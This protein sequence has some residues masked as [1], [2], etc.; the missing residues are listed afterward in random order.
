LQVLAERNQRKA[1]KL[2]S[3]IDS[4]AFYT[5]PVEPEFRSWM[6]VPFILQDSSL[7]AAFLAEASQAGLTNLKGHRS[8]GGM[9][10]SI[11]NAMPEEGIDAL[12]QFM[13]EFERSHG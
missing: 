13:N 12:I 9:R 8:V 4:S 7:D 11:Y 10:A 6:N 1:Q 5:N 2:Y 3:A